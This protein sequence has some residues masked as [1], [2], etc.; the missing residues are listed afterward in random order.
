MRPAPDLFRR[1]Q[2]DADGV[3]VSDR[4]CHVKGARTVQGG[5]P[6]SRGRTPP[7]A[8]LEIGRWSLA[9]GRWPKPAKTSKTRRSKSKTA[10]LCFYFLKPYASSLANDQ[11]PTTN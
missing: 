3:K 9:I 11:G 8:A 7:L 10:G 6:L 2:A 1:G 4:V 5:P